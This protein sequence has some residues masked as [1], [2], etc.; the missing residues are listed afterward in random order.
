MANYDPDA[1]L[2]ARQLIEKR[3]MALESAA[4]DHLSEAGSLEAR[5]AKE[6]QR[7]IEATSEAGVLRT[8][9][10]RFQ[11]LEPYREPS[12]EPVAMGSIHAVK[13]P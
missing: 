4:A 1:G 9:A 11:D 6:R 3:A 7:A 8:A 5:A 2:N 12:L 13:R 10:A